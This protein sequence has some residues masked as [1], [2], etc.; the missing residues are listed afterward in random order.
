LGNSK[1]NCNIVQLWLIAA[2]FATL[3]VKPVAA[4]ET[5][6]L[7][8]A[9]S[10]RQQAL[11]RKLRYSQKP[12]DIDATLALYKSAIDASEKENG[13]GSSYTGYLYF[14]RGSYAFDNSRFNIALENLNK[15]VQ[16]NPSSVTARLRLIQLLELRK[17]SIQARQQIQ[18]L[19][20]RHGDCKEGRQLLV[21]SMQKFD[22]AAATRQAFSIDK[23]VKLPAPEKA[24]QVAAENAPESTQNANLAS[25]AKPPDATP[26]SPVLSLRSPHAKPPEAVPTTKPAAAP[27]SAESAA[28]IEAVTSVQREISKFAKSTPPKESKPE[29]K[30]TPRPAKMAKTTEKKKAQHAVAQAMEIPGIPKPPKGG[31]GKVGLVP[32]PP[33][34]PFSFAMPMVPRPDLSNGGLQL[35]TEAKIKK[36]TEKKA[37]PEKITVPPVP[38]IPGANEGAAPAASKGNADSDPDFLLEWGGANNKKKK[39]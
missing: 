6:T 22:P 13:S 16:I 37:A 34:T 27:P 35:K 30:S 7:N 26:L 33:P 17:E 10:L 5:S 2:A 3:S 11:Q 19:L 23:F 39:K 25:A 14:E 32:P 31:G 29:K 36:T 9:V 18:Q 24:A 28:V 21:A 15:A 20:S 12:E 4:I 1:T 8:S 38:N